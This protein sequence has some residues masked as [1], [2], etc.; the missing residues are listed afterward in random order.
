M[1]DIIYLGC[2]DSGYELK[3]KVI[4]LLKEMGYQYKD[5]GSG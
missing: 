3:M 4:D 2:D 5:C 1:E